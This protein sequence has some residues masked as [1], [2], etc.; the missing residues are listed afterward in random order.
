MKRREFVEQL[1]IGSAVLAAAAGAAEAA[2]MDHAGHHRPLIGPLASATVS[3][4]AW[5]VGTVDEPLDRTVT[6][7]AP[8]AANVHALLPQVALIKEGGSV[9]FVL[10]GFHQVVVY[11]PG[12]KPSDI[13]TTA[14][15]PIPGAPATVGLIDDDTNRIYRGL[16]PRLLSPAPPAPPN[17]LSQDRVEVVGFAKRGTYLVICAVNV[18]FAEGMYGWVRVIR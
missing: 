9:N 5:P 3:F 13:D 7:L 10:A 4:G 12:T 15:L 1:G 2:Q 16:D 6:P 11:A 17:L 18:H 14:L 8:F